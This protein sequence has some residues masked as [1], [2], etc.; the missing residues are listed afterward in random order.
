MHVHMTQLLAGH[1]KLEIG[2]SVDEEFSLSSLLKAKATY[3]AQLLPGPLTKQIRNMA[4]S[5]KQK[6]KD[7]MNSLMAGENPFNSTKLEASA[8]RTW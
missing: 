6:L 1:L 8:M 5:F 2:M 4:A 3:Q 7:A